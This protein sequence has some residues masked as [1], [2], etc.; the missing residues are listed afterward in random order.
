MK[1][2]Y[3]VGCVAIALT[4]LLGDARAFAHEGG[5]GDSHDAPRSWELRDGT[6][7]HGTYI[8]ADQDVLRLLESDGTIRSIEIALLAGKHRLWI[9]QKRME[10]QE[11]NTSPQVRLVTLVNTNAADE[12][13]RPAIANSF[14]AFE[15]TVKVR[16]DKDHLFVE[17]NGIPD[18]AMMVGIRAWQQ[19]VPLPQPYVGENAWRIPLHPVPARSPMTAKGKFLRGAIALAVNG[20]PIFNPLNNRGDDAYLVGELDEFGGH[21]GRAD[22]YHYHIAPVHLEKIVGKGQPIAY[23]LDGYPIL[24]YQDPQRPTLLRWIG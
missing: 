20:I 14:K 16:W 2:I 23:A 13:P 24:G 15:T 18:H 10:V 8:S 7:L 17:S 11:M 4:L 19:Q 12:T 5:H 3:S 9:A 21:C 6:H 22:D 1:K